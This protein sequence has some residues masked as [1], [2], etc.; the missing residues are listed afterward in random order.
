[1]KWNQ[2]Q[3]SM[4]ITAPDN[5]SEADVMKYASLNINA[6]QSSYGKFAAV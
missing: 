1:M 3:T 2:N 5:A 6:Q 4:K